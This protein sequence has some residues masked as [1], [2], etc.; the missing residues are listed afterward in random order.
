MARFFRAGGL[1]EAYERRGDDLVQFGDIV[2]LVTDMVKAVSRDAVKRR[3]L[4]GAKT[5]W[6]GR[7]GPRQTIEQLI[8]LDWYSFVP[9]GRYP[10]RPSYIRVETA[11]KYMR[12]PRSVWAKWLK[13][14][15]WPVPLELEQS[16]AG[17]LRREPAGT[18]FK[19]WTKKVGSAVRSGLYKVVVD[20][21]AEAVKKL[22]RGS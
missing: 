1:C 15:G 16:A 19:R 4:F 13:A 17:P 7:H 18:R 8:D 11:P 9:R 12:A 22:L 20:V 5:G 3:F 6:F 2:D 10:L 21:A 14:Q